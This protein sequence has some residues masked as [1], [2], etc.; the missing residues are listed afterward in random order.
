MFGQLLEN[1]KSLLLPVDFLLGTQLK[2]MLQHTQYFSLIKLP[3]SVYIQYTKQ[4][5]K[6]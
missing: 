6:R 3:I 5:I 4:N 1:L 2:L